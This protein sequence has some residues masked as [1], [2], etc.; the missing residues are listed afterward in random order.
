MPEIISKYPSI[1]IDVLKSGKV[2][3]NTKAKPKILTTC[4]QEQFCSSSGGELCV[5]DVKATLHTSQF[6]A[7]DLLML[8]GLWLPLALLLF[9]AFLGGVYAGTKL[10]K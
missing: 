10:T 4:P 2:S 3:C 8:P 7:A 6:T 1:V 5:Y 9:M